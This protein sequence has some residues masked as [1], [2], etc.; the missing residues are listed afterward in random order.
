[1]QNFP[2]TCREIRFRSPLC[3]SPLSH[4]FLHIL[5]FSPAAIWSTHACILHQLLHCRTAHRKSL[6]WA[7][8]WTSFSWW[9]TISSYKVFWVPGWKQQNHLPLWQE[10]KENLTLLSSVDVNEGCYSCWAQIGCASWPDAGLQVVNSCVCLQRYGWLS[11][12]SY[13]EIESW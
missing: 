6:S 12:L 9:W 13:P 8:C 1:M 10:N 3:S 11:W 7:R 4:H 2:E 5:L